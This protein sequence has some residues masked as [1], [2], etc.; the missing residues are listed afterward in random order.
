MLDYLDH[1]TWDAGPGQ[2]MLRQKSF[3]DALESGTAAPART[4]EEKEAFLYEMYL[5]GERR[6]EENRR[7]KREQIAELRRK[8]LQAGALPVEQSDLELG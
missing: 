1:L 8:Y 6:L 3:Y 5:D 7:K 2:I 4:I